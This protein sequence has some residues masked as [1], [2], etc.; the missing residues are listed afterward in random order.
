LQGLEGA[1]PAQAAEVE[2]WG[3]GSSLHWDSLDV[4]HY[5]PSL[6][7]GVFGNRR[8]MSELGKIGGIS[9]SDAKRAA[10]RKNGHKGC[11]PKKITI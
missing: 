6:I 10:A 8:W 1:T 11:R 7:E 3:P 2:I 5:V 9:R 4:D